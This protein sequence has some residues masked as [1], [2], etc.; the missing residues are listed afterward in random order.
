M[1][2]GAVEVIDEAASPA[3]WAAIRDVTPFAGT[4]RAGGVA[5]VHRARAGPL[6]AA[7]LAAELGAE[8]FCDG[9][10]G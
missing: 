4:R 9:P 2:F 1:P 10:A 5:P 3:V 8:T 6:L 7:K